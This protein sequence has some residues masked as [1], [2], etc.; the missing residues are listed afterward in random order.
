MTLG[1]GQQFCLL[2]S[3]SNYT[4]TLYHLLSIKCGMSEVC[5]P[6]FVYDVPCCHCIVQF[7]GRATLGQIRCLHPNHTLLKIT[8]KLGT[9]E[10][11]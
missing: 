1:H 8:L 2:S 5:I 4:C 11:K 9:R 10:L 3:K 6:E 7:D